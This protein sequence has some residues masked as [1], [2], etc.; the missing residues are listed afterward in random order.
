MLEDGPYMVSLGK[1]TIATINIFEGQTLPCSQA[2][3]DTFPAVW[4]W[5]HYSTNLNLSLL[6][7][8]D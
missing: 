1:D 2:S 4:P 5:I 8:S 6:K 3:S 7:L